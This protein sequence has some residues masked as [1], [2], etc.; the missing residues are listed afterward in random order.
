MDKK[1]WTE[2]IQTAII[3]TIGAVIGASIISLLISYYS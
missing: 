2:R 3:S 1:K